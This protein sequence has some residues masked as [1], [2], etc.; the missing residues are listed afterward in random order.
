M[1]RPFSC[2]SNV[3]LGLELP[4][5]ARKSVELSLRMID[6]INEELE[7]HRGGDPLLRPAPSTEGSRLVVLM[8]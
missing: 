2:F 8:V 7:A 5:A 6:R 3:S 4:A 1:L